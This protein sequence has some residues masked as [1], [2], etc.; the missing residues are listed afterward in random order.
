MGYPKGQV[1]TRNGNR[2][3]LAQAYSSSGSQGISSITMLQGRSLYLQMATE[4]IAAPIY[5][6]R[7]LLKIMSLSH[8]YRVTVLTPYNL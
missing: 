4:L 2:R 6:F 1:Y 7:L 8:V 3:I 5:Y